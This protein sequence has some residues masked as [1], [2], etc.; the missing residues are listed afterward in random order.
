MF[1]YEKYLREDLLPHIWCP[2]CSNGIV[3]KALMRAIEKLGLEQDRVC[4]VSGIGCSSRLPGYLDFK[5]LHTRHRRPLAFAS[6]LKLARPELDV[7]VITGDGDALAI[8]GNHFIHGARRNLDLT[9]ILFNNCVYGM[10]GGQLAPTTP[11]GMF[12]STAPYENIEPPFD[13]CKL[14]AAAGATYVARGTTYKIQQVERL[15]VEGIRHK[16]FALI[17]VMTNCNTYYGRLNDKTAIDLLRWE[18]QAAVD[19][20]LF[21]AME[22]AE[23]KEKFPVGLLHSDSRPEYMELCDE[24][25]AR[26]RQEAQAEQEQQ[27][28]PGPAERPANPLPSPLAVRL[29]GAGGQGLIFAGVIL[30]EA[31]GVYEGR[32]VLQNQVYGPEARG[33]ASKAEVIISDQAIDFPM[34]TEIDLHLALTQE[35]CDRYSSDLKPTGTLIVD[36]TNVSAIPPGEFAVYRLPIIE[37]ARKKL[38]KAPVANVVSLGIAAT[39]TRLVGRDALERAVLARVPKGTEEL[40]R[41]AL[42]VGFALG[43]NA[44]AEPRSRESS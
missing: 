32:H 13:A 35:A 31:A 25:V 8:G 22:P 33:G 43:E 36:A 21:E 37:T 4:L 6:G 14:A 40:N 30:A 26:A 5:T 17:E 12:A 38:G 41:R 29:S 24:L 44:A 39:L 42:A 3:A 19:S 20:E 34:V 28:E 9:T 27:R 2:G 15:I 16:G 7:I 11:L 1:P 23:R 10:T 18:K